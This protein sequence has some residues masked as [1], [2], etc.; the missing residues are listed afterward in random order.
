MNSVLMNKLYKML[1]SV[2]CD[3]KYVVFF[4]ANKITELA[5]RYLGAKGIK[6]NAIIDNDKNKTNTYKYGV[7]INTPESVLGNY[8]ADA[9]IFI[10][11]RYVNEMTKQLQEMGYEPGIHI[12]NTI[13]QIKDLSEN[14]FDE[15]ILTAKRGEEIYRELMDDMDKSR[16]FICPYKGIGDIYFIGAYFN[17]Y[18]KKENVSDYV[19]VVV[20]NVCR[21]VAEMF[22]VQNVKV[23]SQDDMDALVKYI[24]FVGAEKTNAM[25][26]NHNALHYNILTPLE[27]AFRI[28]WG[29]VFLNGVF[30]FENDVKAS[31][32]IKKV[33]EDIE[34]I[35]KGKTVILA[36]YANTVGNIEQSIWEK[37]TE[38]LI[39]M[40]YTV[41]TNSIGESEPVIKGSKVLN[42]PLE[43]AIDVV[44]KAGI[45]IGLRSGLCDIIASANANKI[46]L[47][48]DK[49]SE[50]FSIKKMGLSDDVKERCIEGLLDDEIVQLIVKDI[51]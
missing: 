50:F 5:I 6:V 17:E 1:D 51:V 15:N 16:L 24:G 12:F 14:E 37:L 41:F 30:E 38:K 10:A 49:A 36:P 23:L 9:K 8:R 22:A 31:M 39:E 44:E 7:C 21:R 29:E 43:T 26:L 45:F 19:F 4:G 27:V 32:P 3:N 2:E 13:F 47:Y 11:S 34:V 40:G 35:D 42:F 18:C 48:P 25:I 33:D 28:Y 46:I 20:G